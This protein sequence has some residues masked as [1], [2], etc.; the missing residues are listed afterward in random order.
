MIHNKKFKTKTNITIVRILTKQDC[1]YNDVP[2][3][4]NDFDQILDRNTW[5]WSPYAKI[6]LHSKQNPINLQNKTNQSKESKMD[7]WKCK[8]KNSALNKLTSYM[9]KNEIAISQTK[10]KERISFYK[11]KNVCLFFFLN[12]ICN[13]RIF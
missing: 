8:N 1:L 11:M 2:L 9:E 5:F 12:I 4:E 3:I 7:I 10:W 6:S 13:I